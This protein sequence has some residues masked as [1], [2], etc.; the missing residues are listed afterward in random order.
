[1][2]RLYEDRDTWMAPS[3]RAI[4]IRQQALS[5]EALLENATSVDAM[6]NI[7]KPSQQPEMKTSTIR[8]S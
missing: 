6:R 5:E 7:K 2:E 4:S 8:P 1:M 3:V